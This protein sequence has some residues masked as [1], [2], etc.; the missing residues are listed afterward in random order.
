MK[1]EDKRNNKYNRFIGILES[2]HSK[3][4]KRLWNMESHVDAEM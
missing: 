3:V 2:N 4:M 1:E